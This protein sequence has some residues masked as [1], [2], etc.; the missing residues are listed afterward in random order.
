[1]AERAFRLNPSPAPWA[2]RFLRKAFLNAE[3]YDVALQVHQRMPTTMFIDWD[4]IDGA[5]ILEAL[6]RKDKARAQRPGSGRLSH[7][8]D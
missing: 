4:A 5:V 3:R 2:I 7:D 6:G 8:L 1:M